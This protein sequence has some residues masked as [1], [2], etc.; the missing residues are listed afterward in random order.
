M[1]RRQSSRAKRRA[2]TTAPASAHGRAR[3]ER[4]TSVS[5]EQSTV[6]SRPAVETATT[7]ATRNIFQ[8]AP[9]ARRDGWGFPLFRFA[10]GL[11]LVLGGVA[12]TL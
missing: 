5:R 11:G 10:I 2:A 6:Q 3:R 12:L 9:S 1:A 7:A 4:M 8:V